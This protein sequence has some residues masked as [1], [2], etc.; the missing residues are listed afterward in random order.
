M[1]NTNRPAIEAKSTKLITKQTIAIAAITLTG[2]AAT[3]ILF[4]RIVA[5]DAAINFILDTLEDA[6]I[7][8]NLANK[9]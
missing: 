5:A 9:K 8:Q 7:V 1:T 4:Y 2:L 6:Q 3:S